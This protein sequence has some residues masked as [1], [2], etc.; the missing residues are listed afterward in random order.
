MLK[1]KP[2]RAEKSGVAAIEF[3]LIAPLLILV[4]F[5]LIELAEGVNCRARM[6]N[7]ASSVA[8]LAA[9][10]RNI[11][12]ADR[13][14]IFN[15]ANALMY[16]NPATIKIK[17]SSLVDDGTNSN[18]GRVVWS[19]ATPNET[20]RTIGQIVPLDPGLI[21]TSGSVIMTE[22][23]YTFDS[24]VAYVLPAHKTM[25]SRFY[26]RPRRALQVTRSAT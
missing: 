8:D 23:E 20:A 3:A 18:H 16:P 6:E 11:T 9:Q 22:V 7:T 10:A 15:A 2:I 1:R 19:D 4:F 12:D 21:A 26:S 5:G 13:D 25:T 14:N 17:L 24:P